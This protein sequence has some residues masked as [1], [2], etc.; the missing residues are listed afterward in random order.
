VRTGPPPSWGTAKA[1]APD[2]E[3]TA[4]WEFR[5][6]AGDLTTGL[7]TGAF[8]D[9]GLFIWRS[10]RL[11]LAVR[12]GPVGQRGNGGHAHNDQLHVELTIDG[13]DWT[14]DPG[15]GV[16]T[17]LPEVRN[18]YRSITA[19]FTQAVDGREPSS[20]GLG[21]FTLPDTTKARCLRFGPE[22]FLGQHLGYG[23][24]VIREI[25]VQPQAVLI[26][27]WTGARQRCRSHL[28]TGPAEITFPPIAFSDGYGSFDGFG[29]PQK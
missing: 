22:G 5:P 2:R 13:E 21:L 16:Y 7:R 29:S 3:P 28:V 10:D 11:F 23:I 17:P 19:H 20:L 8:P 14:R 24:P 9:F 12:C 27:D 25:S 6:A 1:S 18:C 4:T 26:R 15:A